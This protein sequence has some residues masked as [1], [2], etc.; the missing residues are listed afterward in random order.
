[1]YALIKK[2]IIDKKLIVPGDNILLGLSGGPDSVFLFHNLRLLQDILNF[3]LYASHINHMYRGEDA[4]HDEDFVRTLCSKYNV[5][6]FV[7][8]KNASEYAEELKCTE[9]EAGRILRY[10]FF[11][12]KL[13]EISGGKIAVAHNL[14][15]Q[16][17]TILQRIIRG[18][19][20]D[21]LAAMSYINKDIIRPMLNVKKSEVMK[22]LSENNYEFCIDS[23][24]LEDIYGRNKIRLNLIPYLEK[25]FNPNIQNTLFRMSE[26]MENDSK[27]IERYTDAKYREVLLEKNENEIHLDITKLKALENFETSRIIRKAIEEFKGDSV[28]IEMKHIEYANEFISSGKTGKKI[29]LTDGI[30]IEISY[31]D[32]IVRK[33]VDKTPDFKYNVNIGE[34]LYIKETGHAVRTCIIDLTGYDTKDKGSIY[35]DFDSLKGNLTVRNRRDGDSMIPSGMTGNRKI[36]D[37]FIDMKIP[38]NERS[39]KLIIADDN[40]ILWLEGFRINNSY[41]VTTATNK[42]LKVNIQEDK[43]EQRYE[44]NID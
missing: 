26:A 18:T 4:K 6:L 37:I 7:K 5:R 38:A 12:E 31:N 1:M 34:P 15:D 3:N 28:N 35:F 36:K 43:N 16:A 44:E 9:E 14:N 13:N 39:R 25:N 19:G 8:R 33:K 11:R 22:Y 27:I 2:N 29:N 17:E 32:Y 41:K 42:I 40:N 30:V 23:T 21:G 10:D 20:I 24:N